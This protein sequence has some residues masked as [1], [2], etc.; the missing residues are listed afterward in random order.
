MIEHEFINYLQY[1]KRYSKHTLT[2]YK[3]DIDDFM[4]YLSEVYE[5][6]QINEANQQ[7]IRSWLIHSLDEKGLSA[8]S[9]NRKL[10]TLKSLFKFARTNQ[11]IDLNPTAKIVAPKRSKRLPE[12]ADQSDIISI[13]ES[14][15]YYNEG[16]K[17]VLEKAVISLF[18]QTG[19]R[20]SE[21]M[22]IRIKDIDFNQGYIQVLGKRNKER[23][24]PLTNEMIA[25]VKSYLSHRNEMMVD[26]GSEKLL[27]VTEKGKP[28]Y[29]SLVYR[30]ISRLLKLGTTL[31]KTSPH[32]LRHSFATHLLNN[33]ADLNTIKELLGHSSL[34]AT[35]V[36]THNSFEQLKN[37]HE[38]AHPRA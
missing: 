1:E 36:Y 32:V 17:G 24:V 23:F 19:M 38:Q 21:L 11:K 6:Q 16:Y 7:M 18:Y 4:T 35:Q 34:A 15:E 30:M 31:K 10:S 25:E 20:L 29:S 9:V 28:L 22:S 12:F 37:I 5:T 14:N 33:G 13:L 8:A 2:S 27:F 26:E 3:K